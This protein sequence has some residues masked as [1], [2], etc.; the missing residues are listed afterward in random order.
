MPQTK[1]TYFLKGRFPPTPASPND[2]KVALNPSSAE[3]L[4][5]FENFRG[6]SCCCPS[7]SHWPLLCRWWEVGARPPVWNQRSD[8][9]LLHGYNP[10]RSGTTSSLVSAA[11]VMSSKDKTCDAYQ[12]VQYTEKSS[13]VAPPPLPST[14]G[15]FQTSPHFFLVS[16]LFFIR[17]AYVDFY[18]FGL[19]WFRTT[20]PPPWFLC[21]YSDTEH[22]LL[23]IF[24][25]F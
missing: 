19:V 17:K 7:P 1:P 14:T 24:E 3:L 20:F 2:G 21:G 22:L 5:H 11:P 18:W 13:S 10:K 6:L 9:V 15:S 4:L 16:L 8:N 23:N 12:V 25:A